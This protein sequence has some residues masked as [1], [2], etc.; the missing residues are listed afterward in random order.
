MSMSPEPQE[1][2]YPITFSGQK[3]NIFLMHTAI[4]VLICFA[5]TFFFIIL[6]IILKGDYQG[7]RPDYE[8]TGNLG[9]L[10][11]GFFCCT[12]LP[13]AGC[14]A[15]WITIRKKKN[16]QLEER[17][18]WMMFHCVQLAKNNQNRLSVPEIIINLQVSADDAK[19]TMDELVTKGLFEIMIT[20]SGA[21]VYQLTGFDRD[22]AVSV[23]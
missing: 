11:A 4:V 22:K 7:G 3:N 8:G 15:L 5:I 6:G 21:L 16:Q 13:L 12:G 14:A 1:F 17:R 19:K 2:K 10:I 23:T 9:G 20:P 18:Q